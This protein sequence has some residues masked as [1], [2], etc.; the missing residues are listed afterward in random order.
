MQM[1]K[2]IS[3]VKFGCEYR[4]FDVKIEKKAQIPYFLHWMLLVSVFSL[5]FKFSISL[6]FH[7]IYFHSWCVLMCVK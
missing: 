2:S 3:L 7:S 4:Q 1:T 5:V 6:Q